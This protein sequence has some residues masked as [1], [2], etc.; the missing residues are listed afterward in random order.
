MENAAAFVGGFVNDCTI[1]FWINESIN[2]YHSVEYKRYNNCQLT[3]IKCISEF[4]CKL[5]YLS[6]LN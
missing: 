4:R 3:P 5:F 1:F 6:T 2:N